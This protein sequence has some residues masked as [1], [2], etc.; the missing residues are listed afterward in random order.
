[1]LALDRSGVVDAPRVGGRDSK[2]L[3][4][5]RIF[6]MGDVSFVT[7]AVIGV[8]GVYGEAGVSGMFPFFPFTLESHFFVEGV[9]AILASESFWEMERRRR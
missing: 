9:M 1:M 6:L 5:R 7:G 4:L 3:E 8:L 2:I